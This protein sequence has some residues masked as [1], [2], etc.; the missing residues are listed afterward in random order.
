MRVLVV[1]AGAIGR[2]MATQL[3][4]ERSADITLTLVDRNSTRAA[5]LRDEGIHRHDERGVHDIRVD[6]RTWETLPEESY[7]VA[8]ICVKAYD[9]AAAVREA[10]SALTP[11][12]HVLLVSNG[13][14]NYERAAE[15]W[16]REQFLLSTVVCGAF[17]DGDRGVVVQGLG[18]IQLGSPTSTG[19]GPD[20]AHSAV[21]ELF[22][23]AGFDVA[24]N[25]EIEA[26]VWTKA[27]INCA[28]NPAAALLQVTN[29]E[30][31]GTPLLV[32]GIE[33]AKE[34]ATVARARGIALPADGWDER[35]EAV[36]RQTAG[37]RSS[38]YEDLRHARPT[39]IEYLCGAVGRLAE[40]SK[41]EAPVNSTLARMVRA[42]EVQ[43]RDAHA[44]G[45]AVPL[46][47]TTTIGVEE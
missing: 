12:A 27:A 36:C 10:R 29:E 18:P 2:L 16:P 9:V 22:R 26:A 13:L 28:I 40:E 41:I 8:I 21:L 3:M 5:L 34:V 43:A 1:G 11:G 24:W 25:D 31:L 15:S 14:G 42:L 4:A 47:G 7:D 44:A 37:N 19:A 33:A 35:V 30:L 6:A 32:A 23:Q 46:V 45:E 17:C 20:P 38:L 39:E